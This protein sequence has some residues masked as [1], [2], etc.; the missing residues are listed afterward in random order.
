MMYFVEIRD[1]Y[2][3]WKEAYEIHG[4]FCEK[5]LW[6]PMFVANGMAELEMGG[7]SRGGKV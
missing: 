2:D 7:N 5:V 3:E 4:R 6:T 1:L